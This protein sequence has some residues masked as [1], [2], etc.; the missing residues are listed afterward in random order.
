[1]KTGAKSPK[2]GVIHQHPLISQVKKSDKGRVARSLA[3][4]ISLAVKLDFF[5]GEFQGDKLRHELE[6]KFSK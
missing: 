2:Y 5:K 4:K 1:M 3:D 6:S